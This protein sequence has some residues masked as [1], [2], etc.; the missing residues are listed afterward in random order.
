MMLY[1]IVLQVSPLLHWEGS[2]SPHV[3]VGWPMGNEYLN[4][5]N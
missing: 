3:E 5:A 2:G 1:I 4:F